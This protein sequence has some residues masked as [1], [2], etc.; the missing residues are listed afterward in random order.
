MCSKKKNKGGVFLIIKNKGGVFLIN[1][2]TLSWKLCFS[3]RK[4]IFMTQSSVGES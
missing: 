2:I 4:C 1:E 3:S